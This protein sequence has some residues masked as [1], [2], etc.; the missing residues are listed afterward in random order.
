[1]KAFP[2]FLCVLSL[3][4]FCVACGGGS[5]SPQPL[6][7]DASLS[8]LSVSG[9]TLDPA[10]S[11]AVTSYTTAVPNSTNSVDVS[12]T[13]SDGNA[14]F[15]IN[16]STNAT[17]ALVVGVNT[18]S[19]VVTAE[20]GTVSSTYTIVVARARSHPPPPPPVINASPG[21]IWTGIDSDGDFVIALVTETGRFNFL[22]DFGNQGSG[23]LSVSNGNDIS[24]N[25]QLVT[26]LGITF[27]DGTTLADC[28]LSGT[29][30][31]R[32]TMTVTADCTTT[33][34]L[35]DQITV[36]LD[37]EAIY[38]RDSSLAT[39]VG[40]YDDG[41]GIVTDIASD[42]TIFE[43]DPVSGCVTNG[44][45]NIID[46]AFNAY[47]V[48][49]GFSNCTGQFAILNGTSFDGIATL[50]NT[51][52]PEALIVA[53]TGNVAG[54]LV[55]FVSVS[56]RLS[57]PPP[58]PPPPPPAAM[59][60]AGIWVGQAV[61]PD[62][63][64]IVT[65]FEFNDANGFIL[66]NAPFTADFQGGVTQ[67][68]GNPALYTAGSFSWHV[69]TADGSADFSTPGDSLVFSTRT[70][71]AGDNATIQVLDE[72]GVQLSSTVV[73]NAFQQ[74][75]V[76]RDPGA[77][78][79]LIGSVVI[80]VTTGE[81]VIDSFTFG[82]VSTASTDD[83]ACLLAPNEDFV[84]VLTD[85][86]TGDLIG[87]A[88]GTYQVNV[89]Q[90]TGSGNLYAAPGETLV[91]GSTIAPL[92][93]SAGTVVGNTTLDLTID[94]F[95]LSIA[96]TSVFDATYDR[97]ADIAT[98]AAMY[99]TADILGEMSA[100]AIDAAGTISGA[101]A[102]GCMLTGQVS[103]IDAAANTYDVNLV[104]NAATCGALSGV[105]DGLGSS[106]DANATDDAFIFAVFVDGQLMIVGE[107][108]K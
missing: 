65:S 95:G 70:V 89:D 96:M 45:V 44:Q 77:G 26:P 34:G 90:V 17:V 7:T 46:P 66:G 72:F 32:Q 28:A 1:M 9:G 55:S 61:T 93:I 30:S 73:T 83:I 88:N 41:S 14:S 54:T 75:V 99:S 85:V 91:D 67:T 39:I 49:F 36:A 6:G 37:Y 81:I 103:V 84:C 76:N 102:S 21:G 35:Q 106:Q 60:A 5:T 23:T 63:P 64:D 56:E 82:F 15:T 33:A 68:L 92:T 43:Q 87:G 11:P 3:T 97:G 12:A 53:A 42:G 2:R 29:V 78:E 10:F 101:T 40:T 94:S 74:I 59:S 80:T 4:A 107:A 8:S 51:V 86:T 24:G 38:D 13:T 19:I 62:V 20:N 57:P 100:F 27:P 25:F 47:D 31:E 104:A 18:I 48:Q 52:T 16:G 79:S 105:Y 50:D 108:I 98:V 22:D 69:D 71:T 58:P